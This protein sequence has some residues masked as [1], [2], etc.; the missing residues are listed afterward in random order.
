VH[1]RGGVPGRF[2]S[3]KDRVAARH[4]QHGFR[5]GGDPSWQQPSPPST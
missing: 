2:A 4:V 1:Q 3:H 5:F